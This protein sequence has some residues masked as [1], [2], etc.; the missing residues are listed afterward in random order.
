MKILW[1]SHLVPYP[2]KGGVLQRSYNLLKEV[3]KYHDVTLVSFN[4]RQFLASSFP[5][6]DNPL[7][8]AVT[9]LSKIVEVAEILDIPENTMP[10]GRHLIALKA[11]L[12][13]KSFNMTWLE[14]KLAHK[15]IESVMK[16]KQ[17]DVVHLDTISLGVYDRHFDNVPVVLNH[18]NFES[19]MLR[20]RAVSKSSFIKSKYYGLE[21]SRLFA[22]ELRHCKTASLNLACSDD[23][24]IKMA[25]RTGSGNFITVPN[26]VDVGYFFPNPDVKVSD[27]SILIVGGLSWYPNREA[28]EYFIS[29]IWPLLK[30]EI[31]GLRVDIVGRNPT[32]EIVDAAEQD[33]GVKV[34]GFVNDVREY[35]WRSQIYLCPIRTGG[36][37]KL[38][39]L[40]AL[41]AGCCIVG[42]PFSCKGIKVRDEQHVFYAEKPAEY[43][44]KIKYLLEHPEIQARAKQAGPQLIREMYDY[45]II[46]EKYSRA[47]LDLSSDDVPL[48][49]GVRAGHR[50]A[51]LIGN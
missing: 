26:G 24:A 46:G 25:R 20:A 6:V 17:F 34:H 19:D 47:L 1:L 22:S 33:D 32:A 31:P 36:G 43:V 10:F 28:V 4:Q 50:D 30:K 39:I 11:L 3:A 27:K 23:D 16:K 5:G 21:A 12:T 2:P 14:S 45:K 41:A 7:E 49:K 51:G 8:L 15:A 13:G 44:S 48:G 18:H 29:E 42:D 37:T 35:L 40:D 38:K 9:E